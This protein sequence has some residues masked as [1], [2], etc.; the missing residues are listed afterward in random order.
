MDPVRRLAEGTKKCDPSLLSACISVYM[1]IP[2]RYRVLA[3]EVPQVP[4]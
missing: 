4:Q 2:V 3:E 1:H